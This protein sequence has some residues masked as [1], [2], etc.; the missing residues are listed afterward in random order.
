[1]KVIKFGGTSVGSVDSILSVK[2]IVER[3][4]EPVIVVVSALGGITDKLIRT[5][6]MAVEGNPLYQESFEEIK[7]RHEEMING[8]IPAGEKRDKLSAAVCSLLEE[9]RSIY[10]GVYLIHD[11]SPKTQAAI[12]SYGE[13]ISSQIVAALIEAAEWFDSR[14]FIKT[15]FK[16][17]KNRLVRELT[18]NLVRKTWQ[19]MPKVSVV[20]GFISTDVESGETTNLGRGGSDYTASI[21]LHNKSKV[22]APFLRLNLKGEDGEQIL[23]AVYSDNYITLM[24]GEQKTVTIQWRKEDARGQQPHI[25]VTGIY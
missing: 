24:P 6:L 7:A 16:A 5:S 21:T 19:K 18:N 9:L 2:K 23:P 17:G 22:P 1:M 14:E 25:E 8:I 13:R 10:Q 15:E 11:L 3:Q 20:G 12:V 4:S